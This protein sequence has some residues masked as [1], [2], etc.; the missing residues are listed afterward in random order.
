MSKDP[1]A[2]GTWAW[3]WAWMQVIWEWDGTM[4]PRKTGVPMLFVKQPSM[5]TATGSSTA[6]QLTRELVEAEAVS[7]KI[8]RLRQA[9]LPCHYL[10][11]GPKY[12]LSSRQQLPSPGNLQSKTPSPHKRRLHLLFLSLMRSI[13]PMTPETAEISNKKLSG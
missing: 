6:Q 2:V 8:S 9:Q 10:S 12:R 5:S 7:W 3:A 1:V 4:A 11:F 13:M